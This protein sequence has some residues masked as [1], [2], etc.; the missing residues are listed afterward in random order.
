MA[1]FIPI[2][3]GTGG[4]V[5]VQASA[6]VVQG[7]ANGTLEITEFARQLG[8]EILIGLLN[9]SVL[10]AVI[11]VYNLIMLPDEFAVTISVAA[12]LFSVVMFASIL[13]TVVP[14]TLEKLHINPALATGP[15]IQISN[16]IIGLIIYVG[17]S[18]M[19]LQWFSH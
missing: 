11:F 14:L 1:L 7:L 2:I 3:G 12:S 17:V 8:K 13:G 10:S 6:I 19:F 4:N 5:G 15:F 16:D 18:S 9:A